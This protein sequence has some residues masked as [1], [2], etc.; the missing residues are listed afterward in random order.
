MKQCLFISL[1][2]IILL[3]SCKQ[4]SQQIVRYENKMFSITLNKCNDSIYDFE[5]NNSISKSKVEG[6]AKLV[7]VE[8]DVPE[9]GLVEDYNTPDYMYQCD[10]T[11]AF[12]SNSFRMN[13]ALEKESR[14]RMDL[15]I[16]E[17]T[18]ADFP[19]GGYT[20]YQ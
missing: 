7:L 4:P 19:D 8:N 13:F 14:E 16:W 5:L 2:A 17:S 12:I 18:L 20:L 15:Q 3:S 10:S 6:N 1:M 11:Y 9:C